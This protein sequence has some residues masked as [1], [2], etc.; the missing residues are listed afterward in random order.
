MIP[1]PGYPVALLVKYLLSNKL[2]TPDS[3]LKF[4]IDYELEISKTSYCGIIPITPL[5]LLFIALDA[6]VN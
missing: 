5:K 3:I 4:F 2:F 1:G 6:S